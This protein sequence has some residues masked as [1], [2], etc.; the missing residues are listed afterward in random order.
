MTCVRFGIKDFRSKKEIY[1]DLLYKYS[2]IASKQEGLAVSYDILFDWVI[3]LTLS[4][5]K[6]YI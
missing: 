6:R 3:T 5:L 4:Y 1:F 2:W